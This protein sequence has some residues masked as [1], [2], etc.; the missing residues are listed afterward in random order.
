MSQ[1]ALGEITLTEK[2]MKILRILYEKSRSMRVYTVNESQEELAKELN[3]TR[4][5]L[6]IHLRKL[7]EAGIIR[8]GRGFIDLTE[9][10]LKFLGLQTAT[11][12]VLIKVEPAKRR[13][14]YEAISK[15]P[16]EKIYRVTGEV[17]LIAIVNQA[18]LDSFL[19]AVSSIEGVRST[20][21]HIVLESLR[22]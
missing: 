14:A 5:A 6:N 1:G 10:A 20:S 16:A 2:Q 22:E 4:Q 17:D 21:A 18:K 7:K 8:T 12:F 19:K 15:L 11:A 9:K 13:Q 3:I